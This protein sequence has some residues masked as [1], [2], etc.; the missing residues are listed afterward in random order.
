MV[1]KEGKAGGEVHGDV[2]MSIERKYRVE[3]LA[4]P[5]W[6]GPKVLPRPPALDDP[7]L[8]LSAPQLLAAW[9][10]RPNMRSKWLRGRRQGRNDVNYI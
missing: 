4:M 8:M 6:C 3:F 9:T 1:Y 10:P 5:S 7:P 2:A